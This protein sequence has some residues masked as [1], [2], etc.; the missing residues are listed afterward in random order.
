MSKT[1][2]QDSLVEAPPWRVTV[3]PVAA[4]GC[5][6]LGC[7]TPGELVRVELPDAD[8]RVLC[9]AC[10]KHYIQREATQ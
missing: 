9:R 8:D 5:S 10:A 6:A 7:T 3:V 4:D 2:S 1:A